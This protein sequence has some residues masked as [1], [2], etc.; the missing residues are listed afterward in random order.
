[1]SATT[2]EPTRVIHMMDESGHTSLGW[3]PQDDEWILPVIRK[4]MADGY[5]FWIVRRDP[6]REVL[7]ERVEDLGE[8]RHVIIRDE[9]SRDLFEKGRIG[10]VTADDEMLETVGRATTAEEVVRNETVAHRPLRGG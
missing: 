4:K 5:A 2:I 10:I 8:T 3:D 6:L 9:D 1:M 7:L